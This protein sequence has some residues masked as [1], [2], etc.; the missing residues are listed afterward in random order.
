[1]DKFLK[2]IETDLKEKIVPCINGADPSLIVKTFDNTYDEVRPKSK[3]KKKSITEKLEE[4]IYTDIIS[5]F[6][7]LHPELMKNNEND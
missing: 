5:E 1:M 7:K 4:S 6:L 3:K 2:K